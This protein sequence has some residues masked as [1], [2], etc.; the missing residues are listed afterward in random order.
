MVQY[1]QDGEEEDEDDQDHGMDRKQSIMFN[2][3]RERKDTVVNPYAA[4]PY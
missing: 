1:L 4:D 3:D 2:Y